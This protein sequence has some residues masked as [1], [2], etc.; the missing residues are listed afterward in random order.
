[1]DPGTCL[2]PLLLNGEG[3]VLGDIGPHLGAGDI[4]ITFRCAAQLQMC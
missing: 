3:A 1:M 4:L 2:P